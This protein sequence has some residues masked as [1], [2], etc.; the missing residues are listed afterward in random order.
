MAVG[1]P[2]AH[3]LD[4][5]ATNASSFVQQP[6]AGTLMGCESGSFS[7]IKWRE[8]PQK[9]LTAANQSPVRRA[10][11]PRSGNERGCKGHRSFREN[12]PGVFRRSR[13]ADSTS[14]RKCEERFGFISH[15]CL[16]KRKAEKKKE[17]R[18][19]CSAELGLCNGG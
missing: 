12:R 18:V 6:A 15:D 2:Q 1:H 8:E 7:Q 17:G 16:R 9:S 5:V 10:Q 4:C 14:P 11:G 3:F 13:L 19:C